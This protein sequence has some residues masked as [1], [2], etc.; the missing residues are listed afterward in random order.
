LEGD[1]RGLFQGTVRNS[2]RLKKA[3]KALL[4]QAGNP[5]VVRTDCLLNTGTV[6]VSY[7]TDMHTHA[8]TLGVDA[9][10]PVTANLTVTSCLRVVTFPYC[11]KLVKSPFWTKG[12]LKATSEHCSSVSFGETFSWWSHI[13][14]QKHKHKCG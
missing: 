14:I 1:S 3:R 10:G 6:S 7:Y 9:T 12:S 2:L 11:R 5:I 8:H 13:A 4:K